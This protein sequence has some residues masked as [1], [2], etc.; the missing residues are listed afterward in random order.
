MKNNTL[1]EVLY[2]ERYYDDVYKCP[3]IF[4]HA[5]SKLQ[6]YN[7]LRLNLGLEEKDLEMNN[8]SGSF[9]TVEGYYGCCIWIKDFDTTEASSLST[10]MH[11]C[12]HATM[13]IFDYV[14]VE[15]SI[16]NEEAF[17]YYSEHL[18]RSFIQLF[19]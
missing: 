18:F 12:I 6:A 13:Y 10:L 14:G 9:L 19:R 8:P 17:A 2:S 11:E 15:I 4:C 1:S 5:G 3:F 16:H 7:E